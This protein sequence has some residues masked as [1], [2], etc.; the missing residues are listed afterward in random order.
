MGE[1]SIF[2]GYVR[3]CT[4]RINDRVHLVG[5]G[6]YY[7]ESLEELKDPVEIMRK[8]TSRL[9][10]LK[11]TEKIIYAPFSNIGSLTID[12]AGDYITISKDNLIFTDK[13]LL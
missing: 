9:R 3:G 10:T 11:D 1:L 7:I 12:S 2:Y 6:D 4:Y 5:N 13:K 8:D